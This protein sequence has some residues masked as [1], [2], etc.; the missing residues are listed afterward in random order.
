MKFANSPKAVIDLYS[1]IGK[2]EGTLKALSEI[3]DKDY[4][5]VF[6]CLYNLRQD[7]ID[8]EEHRIP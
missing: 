3:E 5:F 4:L 6:E 8:L 1:L 2:M 7:F